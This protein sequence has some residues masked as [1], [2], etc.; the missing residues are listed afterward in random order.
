MDIYKKNLEFLKNSLPYAYDALMKDESRFPSKATLTGFSNMKVE[1]DQKSCMLH[2]TYDI[3]REVREMFSAVDEDVEGLVVVGMGLWH[4]KAHIL[5]SFKNLRQLIVVEPDLNVFRAALYSVDMTWLAGQKIDINLIVNRGE[6]E[7]ISLIFNVLQSKSILKVDFICS[8]SYRNLYSGYFEAVHRGF[9]VQFRNF[10]MNYATVNLFFY[11]WAKNILTNYRHKAI[12]VTKFIN[13]FEDIPIIIVSAGPSLNYTMQYLKK[14]RD[15]AVIIAVGSAIRILDSNGIV[16]HF[17]MAADG[18]ENEGKI[19][20]G[21]D[22]GNAPL[23]FADTL[24]REILKKYQG[25]KIRMVLSPGSLDQYIFK[26]LY[27]DLPLIQSGFSIANIALDL[28]LKLGAKKIILMGQDL[29]YTEGSLYANG[30]WKQ[31]EDID[32]EKTRYIK[33]TNTLGETVYTDRPFLGM[34]D[35]FEGLIRA[36]PGPVYINATEKGLNIEGTV[37]KPFE[38]VME[39]DL[40]ESRNVDGFINDLIRESEIDDNSWNQRIEG[41]D[42]SEVMEELAAAN[43]Y[44]VKKLTKLKKQAEKDAGTNKLN[45]DLNEIETYASKQLEELEFYRVVVKPALQVKF[46]TL[47]FNHQY[48]GPDEKQ[49]FDNKFEIALG[50]ATEVKN[51]LDFLKKVIAERDGPA[52]LSGSNEAAK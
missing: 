37:N 43:E 32:F 46:R 23:I 9:A 41:L 30:S 22:T 7:T 28:V 11:Q 6:E 51:Y 3:E 35:L 2:S 12:P 14:L 1:L 27:G 44:T 29:S 19:F 31:D 52:S 33:T 5:D 16:P 39:E 42:F 18:G 45:R 40:R 49:A 47:L 25:E 36:N 34:R 50:Q 24:Y 10:T 4:C 17:R 13:R 38:R 26:A 48:H 20:D 8:L 21:I 15:R